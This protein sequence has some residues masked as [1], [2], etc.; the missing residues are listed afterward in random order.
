[1]LNGRS[2]KLNIAVVLDQEIFHGGGFQYGLSII[3]LLKKNENEKY[4]FIFF[5]TFKKNIATLKKITLKRF[6]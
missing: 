4:N 6:I 5:T 3:L 2:L 1:M